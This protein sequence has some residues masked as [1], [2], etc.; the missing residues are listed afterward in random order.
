MF[1]LRG[2]GWA[3]SDSVEGV[4]KSFYDRRYKG[5]RGSSKDVKDNFEGKYF[6][7]TDP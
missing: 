6:M 1:L 3:R 5:D 4:I 2:G 7:S